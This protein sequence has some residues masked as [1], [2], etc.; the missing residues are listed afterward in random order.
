MRALSA[1]ELLSVWESGAGQVPLQ[2]ALTMLAVAC[3]EASSDSLARLTI[4]QRDARLLALREMTFGSELTGGTDCPQCGEKIEL[5]FDCSDLRP[6]TETEPP[7]ELAV[8][9]NGGEVRF[10]LPTSAD[11]LA[12]ESPEQLL[13]RCLLSR[14]DHRTEEFVVAVSEKMSGA[15]PMAEVHLALNCPSC[16]HKWEAPFDIVAFLWR[17]ISAAARRLL[18]EVHTLA[19]AYGWTETEILALSPARRRTYLEIVN[20]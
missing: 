17:E 13:E 7:A 2:R 12:I 4:G 5:S 10:R 15:D 11:L 1:K 19:S 6:A 3:P 16:K 14:V 8:Q 18:S 9:S 20:A